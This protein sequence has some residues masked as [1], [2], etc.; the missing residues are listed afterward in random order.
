MFLVVV[1]PCDMIV[2]CWVSWFILSIST[3]QCYLQG[4]IAGIEIQYQRIHNCAECM[5]FMYFMPYSCHTEKLGSEKNQIARALAFYHVLL[6]TAITYFNSLHPN[7]SIWT[8]I[9]S[10]KASAAWEHC[11]G[12]WCIIFCKDIPCNEMFQLPENLQD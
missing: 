7:G 10:L 5:S 1:L 11:H 2:S 12:L 6:N 8:N 9:H 3:V 4:S